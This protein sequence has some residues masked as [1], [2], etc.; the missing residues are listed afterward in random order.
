MWI[1][2]EAFPDATF[3]IWMQQGHCLE[4][5]REVES[6]WVQAWRYQRWTFWIW[7]YLHLVHAN[8]QPFAADGHLL[9]L[10]GHVLSTMPPFEVEP[11][12]GDAAVRRMAFRNFVF[13]QWPG[14]TEQPQRNHISN[15]FLSLPQKFVW[16]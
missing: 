9:T 1:A 2:S 4:S 10:R 15:G 16:A 14:A 3:V 13:S 11:V 8:F 12:A 7:K 6:V 5:F